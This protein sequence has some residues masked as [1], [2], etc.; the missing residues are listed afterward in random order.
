MRRMSAVIDHNTTWTQLAGFKSEYELRFGDDLVATMKF[1]KM[2]SS[3][4][5][6]QCEE[7][8]WTI[9]RVGFFDRKTVVRQVNSDKEIANYSRRR[10]NRGG[11][12]ELSEGRTLALRPDPWSRTM[13]VY[14]EEG[15]PIVTL[16]GR[17]IFK[18]NVDLSMSRSALHWPELPLLVAL[19]FYQMIMARRD[20]AAH[21][22][23]H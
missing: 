14:K 19:A 3:A 15:N 20:A 11:I 17:G 7:G 23:A 13:E 12:I 8:I 10:W 4:A 18:Y 22:A 5:L 1:P 21:S 2:L 9:E 16:K 6:F